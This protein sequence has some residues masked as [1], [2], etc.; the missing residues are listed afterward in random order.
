LRGAYTIWDPQRSIHSDNISGRSKG[1][2]DGIDL[3]APEGTQLYACIDGEIYDPYFSDSYGNTITIKGDY[4]GTTYYFFYAHLKKAPNLKDGDKV[5]AGDP[6][7][8][9]GKT[10]SSASGLKPNQ[11]HLHFE[12][13]TKGTRTGNRVDP[14]ATI[15]ELNSDVIK[16]PKESDQQ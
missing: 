11:V 12:V 5:K 16:N 4:N 9:S 3:Y 8:L 1:K 13:R 2:H 15:S 10:G 14:L 7:G 6:I